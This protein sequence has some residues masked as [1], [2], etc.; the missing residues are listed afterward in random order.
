M[1]PSRSNSMDSL[2]MEALLLDIETADQESQTD[3]LYRMSDSLILDYIILEQSIRFSNILR[4]CLRPETACRTFHKQRL[5][6]VK[7]YIKQN[8]TSKVCQL[9]FKNLLKMTKM[10]LASLQFFSPACTKCAMEYFK[11]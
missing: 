8:H 5:A 6:I 2:E 10:E 1:D 4:I 7:R 11:E 3:P 9:F